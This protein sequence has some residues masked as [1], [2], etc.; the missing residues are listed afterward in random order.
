MLL[1]FYSISKEKKKKKK[2]RKAKKKNLPFLW[3][4]FARLQFPYKMVL[5]LSG[6]SPGH[7]DTQEL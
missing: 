5:Q 1:I 6:G 7:R 4:Y 3:N 2:L